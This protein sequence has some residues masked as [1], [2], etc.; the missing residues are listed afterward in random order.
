MLVGVDVDQ[1]GNV[2]S[3]YL[4]VQVQINVNKPLRRGVQL[5]LCNDEEP[6]GSLF[7]MSRC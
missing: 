2:C 7:A 3:D 6:Q 5:K 1:E 4:R